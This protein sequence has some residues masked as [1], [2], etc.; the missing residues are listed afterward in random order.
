M[1]WYIQFHSATRLKTVHLF[2]NELAFP[3]RQMDREGS[4]LG[5]TSA[6][7]FGTR[8]GC[9][10]G[11]ASGSMGLSAPGIAIRYEMTHNFPNSGPY[12]EN[13]A[14]RQRLFSPLL[15]TFPGLS[16]GINGLPFYLVLLSAA[17]YDNSQFCVVLEL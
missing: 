4:A 10:C 15:E 6:I 11:L 3:D 7:C 16:W 1:V 13:V 2:L 14:K 8:G 12:K 17:Y 5:L 9:G